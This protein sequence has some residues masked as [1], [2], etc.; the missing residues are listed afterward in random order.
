VSFVFTLSMAESVHF[1]MLDGVATDWAE[2]EGH[3]KSLMWDCLKMLLVFI[4]CVY[5][6]H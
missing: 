4:L 3:C 1:V 5:V 2:Y 6:S